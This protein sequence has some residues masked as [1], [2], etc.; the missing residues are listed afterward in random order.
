MLVLVITPLAQMMKCFYVVTQHVSFPRDD[1]NMQ[2]C[3]SVDMHSIMENKC[4]NVVVCHIKD[5]PGISHD[6]NI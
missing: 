6:Q 5:L 4:L 1:L 3:I 2:C